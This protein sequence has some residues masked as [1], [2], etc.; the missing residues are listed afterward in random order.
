MGGD[1]GQWKIKI[2]LKFPEKCMCLQAKSFDFHL[3]KG[4]FL[5]SQVSSFLET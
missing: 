2:Y 5:I 3:P 1:F 4:N